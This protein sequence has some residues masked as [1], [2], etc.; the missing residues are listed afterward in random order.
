LSYVFGTVGSQRSHDGPAG[1][2]ARASKK[3]LTTL[4]LDNP[5][6]RSIIGAII[7]HLLHSWTQSV[8]TYCTKDDGQGSPRPSVGSCVQP[9]LDFVSKPRQEGHRVRRA[10]RA[11]ALAPLATEDHR[12]KSGN[13]G[14]RGRRS[15]HSCLLACLV[16]V[17]TVLYVGTGG[18]VLHRSTTPHAPSPSVLFVVTNKEGPFN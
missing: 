4:L 10:R 8:C 12:T 11:V 16:L 14:K 18:T 3:G 15:R 6:P 9:V 1:E 2:L 7:I 13:T 5:L 17:W